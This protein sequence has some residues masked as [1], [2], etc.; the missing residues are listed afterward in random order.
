MAGVMLHVDLKKHQCHMSFC[1]FFALPP[2]D[3]KPPYPL[4]DLGADRRH[5]RPQNQAILRLIQNMYI[6]VS[7]T[8]RRPITIYNYDYYWRGQEL[9]SRT[10]KS[11]HVVLKNRLVGMVLRKSP[12]PMSGRGLCY[13]VDL[14]GRGSCLGQT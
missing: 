3:F 2:V 4:G 1:S 12:C 7:H 6:P 11:T 5:N 13:P 14:K 8:N 10:G 9:P